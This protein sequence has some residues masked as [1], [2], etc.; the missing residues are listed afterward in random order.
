MNS[1]CGIE[2]AV[3]SSGLRK[4]AE[5]CP[6]LLACYMLTCEVRGEGVAAVMK[7]EKTALDAGCRT[8]ITRAIINFPEQD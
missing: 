3:D 8:A 5:K 7:Q 1:P 4:D 2:M 6:R